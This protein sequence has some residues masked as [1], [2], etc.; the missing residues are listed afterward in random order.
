MCKTGVV[1][2]IAD[3]NNVEEGA[4]KILQVDSFDQLHAGSFL[5]FMTKHSTDFDAFI[6]VSGDGGGNATVASVEIRD[7]IDLIPKNLEHSERSGLVTR[8]FGVDCDIDHLKL[9]R[10][11]KPSNIVFTELFVTPNKPRDPKDLI[12]SIKSAPYLVDLAS[13]C[14]W[15]DAHDRLSIGT[16]LRNV[17]GCN[18]LCDS[19]CV[20]RKIWT[21]D[22]TLSDKL[23]Q[24]VKDMSA[25]DTVL[26]IVS[27]LATNNVM[28]E[29][30]LDYACSIISQ[31]LMSINTL[32]GQEFAICIDSYILSCLRLTPVS[33]RERM[34]TSVWYPVYA[35]VCGKNEAMRSRLSRACRDE[36]DIWLLKSVGL[37]I[38]IDRSLA[39]TSSSVIPVVQ[40]VVQPIVTQPSSSTSVVNEQTAVGGDQLQAPIQ[41][42]ELDENTPVTDV[43]VAKRI[44]DDIISGLTID[45]KPLFMKA[46]NGAMTASAGALYTDR[47]RALFELIQNAD[48]NSY[49]N[50]IEPTVIFVIEPDRIVVFNNELGFT[51]SHMQSLCCMGFSSKWSERDAIG[52]KG[53]G[54]KSTFGYVMKCLI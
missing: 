45:G 34:W 16:V 6:S 33:W 21:P 54:F 49:D 47:F 20:Y 13:Y 37:S 36:T 48:D 42:I 53:I 22:Y 23:M 5:K 50:G 8:Q 3:M 10:S 1:R 7:F 43:V 30:A 2:S 14:H 38:E 40:S 46:F 52:Q 27:K 11:N 29:A 15:T 35:G 18:F 51:K 44:I 28:D 19:G 24:S 41:D 9:G 31:Q 12:D 39:V 32:S 25:I 26:S 4:C 17:V